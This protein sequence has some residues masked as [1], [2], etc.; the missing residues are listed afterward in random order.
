MSARG[1]TPDQIRTAAR[2]AAQEGVT[3]E[4]RSGARLY[5]IRPTTQDDT[6]DELALDLRS[7]KP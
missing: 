2:I 7:M 4:I 1:L 6:R 5:T 3:I